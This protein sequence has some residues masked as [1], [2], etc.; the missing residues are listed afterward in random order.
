MGELTTR[1]IENLLQDE[2]VCRLACVAEK[3][4]YVVPIT[5]AYDGKNYIYEENNEGMLRP[6]GSEDSTDA[7]QNGFVEFPS[8]CEA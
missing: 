3:G 2:V 7:Y 4:A 5:Y 1:E 8:E 6:E